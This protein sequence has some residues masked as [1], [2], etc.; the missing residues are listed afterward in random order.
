[1]W[2]E[3]LPRIQS[4][5]NN[6]FSLI[7]SKIPNKIAYRLSTR[8]PL[9]LLAAIP[10]PDVSSQLDVTDAIAFTTANSKKHYDR[11]YQPLFIK[12]GEWAML[13]LYKGYSIFS[14]LGVTK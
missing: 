2:P 10:T 13:C 8:R 4:L 9:D 5:L 14:I 12:V 11:R 1:M 7:T 3:I 6:T